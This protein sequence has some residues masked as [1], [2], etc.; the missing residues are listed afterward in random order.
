MIIHAPIRQVWRHVLDY[1]A[2]QNFAVCRNVSGEPGKEGE[3]VML[4]KEEKGFDFPTYYAIT[5]KMDAPHRIMWK[6][7]PE[8]GTQEVD[9]FG[10]VEF[11]LAE[12]ADGT[13]FSCSLIYEFLVPHQS[14]SELEEYR[15]QQDQNFRHLMAVTHPKLKKLAEAG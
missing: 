13:R 10:I 3:V 15:K 9:F 1:P 14:A 2:W 11:R 4:R 8:K 7:W 6:T 5:I 12:A